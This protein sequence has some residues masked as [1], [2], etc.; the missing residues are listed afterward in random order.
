MEV[1]LS[2][3]VDVDSGDVAASKAG[4]RIAIDAPKNSAGNLLSWRIDRL[5]DAFRILDIVGVPV[6]Y[7]CLSVGDLCNRAGVRQ[8]LSH[9]GR[10][11]FAAA[12][13]FIRDCP[14]SISWRHFLRTLPVAPDLYL[15]E[16]SA[17]AVRSSRCA[18]GVCRSIL[19]D[20]VLVHATR[21]YAGRIGPRNAVVYTRG[22]SISSDAAEIQPKAGTR[23][24]G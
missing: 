4:N 22:A 12:R 14:A 5:P 8:H 3:C 10:N 9:R 6:G 24:F 23:A 2:R 19:S 18:S 16:L 17:D 21:F 13:A 1:F 15:V 20:A 7:R 11:L